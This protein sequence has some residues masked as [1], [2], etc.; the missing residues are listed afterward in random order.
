MDEPRVVVFVPV[1]TEWMAA[2]GRV[3]SRISRSRMIDDSVKLVA[4]R[5]WFDAWTCVG[6]HVQFR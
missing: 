1:S 2:G 5:R 6:R 3:M 4:A